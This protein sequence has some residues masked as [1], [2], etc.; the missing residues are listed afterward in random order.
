MGTAA[1]R[2]CAVLTAPPGD[3]PAIRFGEREVS[4]GEWARLAREY[5]G[6]LQRLE[7]QAGDR[8]AVL[9]DTR[10]EVLVALAGHH[11]GGFIH[12]PINTRYREAEVEHILADSGA[13]TI[14]VDTAHVDVL[15]RIESAAQLRRV[16]IDGDGEDSFS[17]LLGRVGSEEDPEDDD[18]AVI[19]Y[20]SGTTG[21]SKGVEL[22]YRAIV[23]GIGRL[24][25]LWKWTS[26]DRLALA[27]PIFHVHGLCIGIHGSLLHGLCIEL[28][29]RFE[30]RAI[31][32]A[33]AAGSTIFMGVPT[34]Y[35]LLLEELERDPKAADALRGAR[36]FTSGSAALSADDSLEFT[37][38]TGH[39]ILERY[40]MTETLLTLSNPYD[41]ER[42]PG[43]VGLPLP[44]CETRVTAE[45]GRE[46]PDGVN[47]ELWLRWPGLMSG[48][49]GQPDATREAFSDGWF[50]TGDV[51]VRDGDGYFRIAGG[52]SVDIRKVGGFKVS[53]RDIEEVL[54]RHP[55]IAQCAIVGVPDSRWGHRIT[56]AIVARP[57]AGAS[58]SLPELANFVAAELADYKKPRGLLI[59]DTLP[60][61]ALGKLQKHRILAEIAKS[62]LDAES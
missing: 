29:P 22:S 41:G 49:W 9:S 34:M 54:A 11:L 30:A 59:L 2:L 40:G 39:Q 1:S 38:R 48:Y 35:S 23:E 21:K 56:A 44:A 7:I 15:D 31:I 12:V 8:V 60:R 47:G 57:D 52:K 58:P 53:A 14:V 10:P 20:T 18:T 32:D 36:L 24:T 27:L 16:V 46:C 6:G 43:S 42:R 62:G 51:V 25:N 26:E 13:T 50:R 55:A 61:N 45:D 4:F 19:I 5:A 3:R 28:L 37:R 33:M 17:S